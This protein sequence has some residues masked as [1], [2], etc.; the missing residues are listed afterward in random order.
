MWTDVTPRYWSGSEIYHESPV[1]H[2]ALRSIIN[3]RHLAISRDVQTELDPDSIV[4]LHYN[5]LT[6]PSQ[7]KYIAF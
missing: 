7:V 5:H 2:V 4:A 6:P 3:V 1:A